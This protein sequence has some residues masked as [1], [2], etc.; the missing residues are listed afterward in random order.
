MVAQLVAVPTWVG[1]R[2]VVPARWPCLPQAHRPSVLTDGRR[3][4]RRW[5]SRSRPAGASLTPGR[6]ADGPGAGPVEAPAEQALGRAEGLGDV[7]EL[8]G[9][10]EQDRETDVVDGAQLVRPERQTR[11]VRG[12]AQQLAV[13]VG[14]PG[15][16][17]FDRR[18][19]RRRHL[20][21]TTG[22]DLTEPV[23]QAGLIRS[24]EQDP[25]VEVGDEPRVGGPGVLEELVRPVDEAPDPVDQ[26][27][28]AQ[29]S[30]PE[31]LARRVRGTIEGLV[32]EALDHDPQPLI[33]VGELVGQ[34]RPRHRRVEPGL[35]GGHLVLG[36]CPIEEHLERVEDEAPVLRAHPAGPG[37]ARG[38][39][40]RRHRRGHQT[41]HHHR[42]PPPTS[43]TPL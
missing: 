7:V 21:S 20:T 39:L 9:G 22:L 34:A 10:R 16:P 4:R 12:P 19:E 1:T 23:V 13:E 41:H 35:P 43:A 25:A 5:P 32:V 15:G 8:L 3:R 2:A 36:R 31:P 37:S 6:S 17:R 24:P 14:D 38:G 30:D 40:R 27:P 26:R 29:L 11:R 33:R 28:R 42:T 18:E